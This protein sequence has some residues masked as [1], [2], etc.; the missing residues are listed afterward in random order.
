MY[1]HS[2]D[3]AR[4]GRRV[5]FIVRAERA[6]ERLA[7]VGATECFGEVEYRRKDKGVVGAGRGVCE[8][9]SGRN[10]Q[11]GR[12]GKRVL[13]CEG[14]AGE[15]STTSDH[16]PGKQW[17]NWTYRSTFKLTEC[18]VLRAS[19][20]EAWRWWAMAVTR[21]IVG[22]KKALSTSPGHFRSAKTMPKPPRWK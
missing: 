13:G 17:G 2:A 19:A 21:R 3:G 6:G 18:G 5:D 7:Y 4:R 15:A 14:G 10:A 11:G 20:A 8:G 1:T 12:V 16:V 9:G 22:E